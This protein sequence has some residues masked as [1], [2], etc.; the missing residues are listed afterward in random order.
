MEKKKKKRY[1][2]VGLGDGHITIELTRSSNP[3]RSRR[4]YRA[5]RTGVP[6]ASSL[7]GMCS[8]RPGV[9][10]SVESVQ[11]ALDRGRATWR[12]LRLFLSGRGERELSSSARRIMER[13]P[14][15][16]ASKRRAVSRPDSRVR[17]AHD[18]RDHA[19]RRPPTWQ[20][21]SD[22]GWRR[23]REQPS[24][25]RG[26]DTFETLMDLARATT[27][28]TADLDDSERGVPKRW[29]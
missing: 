15:P 10:A 2:Y 20:L 23:S 13:R 19:R 27:R 16:C 26:I 22:T 4:L 9:P 6:M 3:P 11:R 25:L 8:I 5:S 1:C 12:P 21:G 28:V 7:I 17:L 18:P 24:E 14:R 29:S